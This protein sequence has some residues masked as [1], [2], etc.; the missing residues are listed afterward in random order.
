[1]HDNYTT[2]QKAT[3]QQLKTRLAQGKGHI[4]VVAMRFDYERDR[5][6]SLPSVVFVP[7]LNI[8]S[9]PCFLFPVSCSLFPDK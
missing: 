4:T 5:E 6:R 3:I 9:V 8:N 1:M 7:E 2:A